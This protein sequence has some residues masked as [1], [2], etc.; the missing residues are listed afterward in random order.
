MSPA[1]A[2]S[3]AGDA[4]RKRPAEWLSAPQYGF[5]PPEEWVR[6][7]KRTQ[8]WPFVFNNMMASFLQFNV[9]NSSR[10]L[11]LL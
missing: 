6:F 8:G 7:G 5:V 10:Y 9:S 11:P 1:F 3:L 4:G 2:E